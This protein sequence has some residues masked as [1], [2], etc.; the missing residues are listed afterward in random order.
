[1]TGSVFPPDELALDSI[2]IRSYDIGDGVAHAD[3]VTASY[4]HLRTYMEW[5]K[6]RQSPLE[7]ES[8]CRRFR[9]EYLLRQ[10][11]TLGVFDRDAGVLLGGT[12]FH[13]RGRRYATRYG[14]IGMWIHARHAGQGL[15]T[16]VLVALL[17]WGF[18]DWP[19]ERLEW[20]CDGDNA[21]SRR[22]AE[23]AGMELEARLKNDATP[24]G[25][26]RD[27][28]IYAAHRDQWAAP[29]ILV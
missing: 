12:G 22:V 26:R 13:L 19:W 6:P 14:E 21:A 9:A 20:R 8:L 16:R 7:S 3:A 29:A 25:R 2:V 27:T 1:V 17:D 15:G 18:R 24:T 10:D 28:L 4:E 5:A 11:F 23:K